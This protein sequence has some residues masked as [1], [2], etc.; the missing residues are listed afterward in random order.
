M[1]LRVA[2]YGG[3]RVDRVRPEIGISTMLSRAGDASLCGSNRLTDLDRTPAAARNFLDTGRKK[4][5][6]KSWLERVVFGLDSALRRRQSIIEYTPDPNCILRIK[7]CHVD[8]DAVLADGSSVR[9]GDRI[10]DLHLWNE[11]IPAMPEQGASIAW[12]RQMN[13]CFRFSLQALASYLAA[14]SDL[15]DV[16][17]IRCTMTFGGP[18]RNRQMVRLI[19]RYGFEP[20][21]AATTPTMRERAHR[22]GENILISLMVLVRNAAALRRDTLR[23]GRTQ[24][25]LPR[26][27]LQQRYGGGAGLGPACPGV[28]HRPGR[29]AARPRRAG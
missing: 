16:A 22:F 27:L 2:T 10:I 26:Q 7:F 15:D 21:S 24:V 28:A 5:S 13:L 11:Q 12:A 3:I 4:P 9:A 8:A 23:R 18:E 1:A 20:V 6:P 29:P 25:F 14:R 17:L 19:G